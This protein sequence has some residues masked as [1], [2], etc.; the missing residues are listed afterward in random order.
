MF[1]KYLLIVVCLIASSLSLAEPWKPTGNIQVVVPF[2]VG[3]PIDRWGRVVSEILTDHGWNSVVLNKPGAGGVIG[4]NYAA[5]TKSNDTILL[6]MSPTIDANL[7]FKDK[8]SASAIEYNENSFSNISPLGSGSLVLAV[9]NNIPVSNYSE[10]KEYIRANP[11]KFNIGFYSNQTANLFYK[12]AEQEKLPKP[13]IILYKG[14]AA[15]AT[16]LAG[17]HVPFGFDIYSNANQLASAKKFKIIA[18]IDTPGYNRLKKSVPGLKITNLSKSHPNL[19]VSIYYG[20]VG[21]AD[22]SKAAIYEIN[23]VINE[24]LTNPKYSESLRDAYYGV[25]GGTP[26]QL[27]MIRIK[28]LKAITSG[29]TTTQ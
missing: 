14:S 4:A 10:F 19:D 9:A 12:W 27:R 21:Q 15:M 1:K 18:V 25:E 6:L 11:S 8:D 13:N 5:N 17:G 16:D 3:G 20:L 23:R 26:E 24:N 28:N 7:A 29:V 22:L 2:A